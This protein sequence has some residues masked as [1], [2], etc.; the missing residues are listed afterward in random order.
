MTRPAPRQRQ[1]GSKDLWLDAAYEMLISEGIEA[2][3]IMPLAKRLNLTRTGFYWFF[4]DLAE[5]HAAMIERLQNR[6]TDALVA[7]CEKPADSL[8]AALFHVMDCWLDPALFD[9][10]LDLAIRNW[11]R[12]DAALLARVTAADSRRIEAV[13]DLFLRHGFAPEQAQVRALTVM[14]TQIGYSSMDITEPRAER[15]ARVQ[16]YVELFAGTPPTPAEAAE[17]LARHAPA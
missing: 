13:R 16:H 10:R 2:V 4:K 8:C 14:L 12:N 6:N 5:L 1:R 11:A 7:Q 3:K 17:F 9:G 15:L